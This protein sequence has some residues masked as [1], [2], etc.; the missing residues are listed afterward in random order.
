MTP[1]LRKC[2]VRF[3]LV[4]A[5]ILAVQLPPGYGQASSSQYYGYEAQYKVKVEFVRVRM[6]DGV[7]VAAR[8]IRPDAEGRFP[9]IMGYTPYRGLTRFKSSV[10]SEQ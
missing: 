7:E 4:A 6:R 10:P 9:A 5:V 2:L 1:V 3:V 8:I